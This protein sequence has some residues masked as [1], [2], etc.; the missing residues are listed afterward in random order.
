MQQQKQIDR[1]LTGIIKERL[2]GQIL[3]QDSRLSTTS[4]YTLDKLNK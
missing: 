2:F 1:I 4:Y 3:S